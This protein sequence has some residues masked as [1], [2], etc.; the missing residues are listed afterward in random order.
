[1]RAAAS[2]VT[3]SSGPGMTPRTTTSAPST[4]ST[5][6]LDATGVGCRGSGLRVGTVADPDRAGDPQRVGRGERGTDRGD[7]GA[8]DE[9][10]AGP[11]GG[12]PP[13]GVHG[14]E[15][16]PEPGETGQP[17][18]RGE[19]EDQQEAQPRRGLAQRRPG[20]REVDAP[21][22]LLEAADEEEQHRRDDAVRDV[23]EQGRLHAR[24]G[25]G[26]EGEGHE[27]H[28]GHGRV[29]D[30][31]LEVTFDEADQGTPDDADHPGDPEHGGEPPE[32]VGNAGD[33]EADQPVGAHLEQHRREQHRAGGRCRGV[34]R[35][36]PGVQGEDGHLD[37]QPGDE[38]QG[39]E[40][41]A[42]GGQRGPGPGGQGPQ[43]GGAGRGDQGED[44]DEHQGGA[45]GGVE[46][47][48]VTGVGAGL[49][50]VPVAVAADEQPHR[51][52]HDLE[53][54]EEEHGVTGGEGG[55]CP[56]L[57][58]QEAAEE[59][60][61]G[62]SLGHVDPGM[63]GDEHPDDRRE[64]HEGHGDAVD[65]ERPAQAELG[66]PGQ[67]DVRACDRDDDGQH[68]GEPSGGR[69]GDPG[70]GDVERASPGDEPEAHDGGDEQQQAHDHASTP[71][72]PSTTT[73][74][75][76]RPTA[77]LGRSPRKA[78]PPA[79][80]AARVPTAVART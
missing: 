76:T 56:C 8:G 19:P 42:V 44:A 39:H 55:Q 5:R 46:D 51:H 16:A 23:G 74:P 69:R 12:G 33:R 20:D 68:Q 2:A 6:E 38:E 65:A 58:D 4:P 53:G 25:A 57:D 3:E 63:G 54:D 24:L 59:R 22:A 61:G 78:R 9:H 80:P 66:Q 40:Q 45:D 64:E 75:R 70:A 30:E 21:P 13:R 37:R 47:E 49:L 31:P 41:L 29:G 15:L 79:H 43:V 52:E 27:A 18:A 35:R 11:V 17:Q 62:T 7:D 10:P 32:A 36:E 26:R 60:R 34:R 14:E 48:P 77:E 1:M 67:V 73:A 71:A 50:V 28:V 72:M